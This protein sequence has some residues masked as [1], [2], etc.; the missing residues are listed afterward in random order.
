MAPGTGMQ[1]VQEDLKVQSGK[2]AKSTAESSEEAHTG[3][4][5]EEVPGRG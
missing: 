4:T 5:Q 3:Q 1:T 2:E